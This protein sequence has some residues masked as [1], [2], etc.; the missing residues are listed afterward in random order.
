MPKNTFHLSNNFSKYNFWSTNKLRCALFYITSIFKFFLF[1]CVQ[2]TSPAKHYKFALYERL[3]SIKAIRSLHN[4]SK[5]YYS[6]KTFSVKI[7]SNLFIHTTCI[8]RIASIRWF[9]FTTKQNTLHSTHFEIFAIKTMMQ[10]VYV[11]AYGTVYTLRL[12][13]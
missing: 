4:K 3:Y 6:I 11:Y 13:D 10:N 12:M 8:I 2:K 1:V 5:H 7:F 9:A